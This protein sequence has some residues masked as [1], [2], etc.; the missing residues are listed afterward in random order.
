MFQLLKM[1]KMLIL[2]S[3][4]FVWLYLLCIYSLVILNSA[5]RTY[6][7]NRIS[8]RTLV[9]ERL[10]HEVSINNNNSNNE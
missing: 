7:I 1:I 5:E 6:D 10:V 8:A 2:Q 4:F 9:I 3:L